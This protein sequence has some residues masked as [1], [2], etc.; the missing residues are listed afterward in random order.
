MTQPIRVPGGVTLIECWH[1][2][3]REYVELKPVDE[4]M[5]RGVCKTCGT[6]YES[7]VVR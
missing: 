6:V 1:G 3:D 7:K 4:E 2:A 5:L